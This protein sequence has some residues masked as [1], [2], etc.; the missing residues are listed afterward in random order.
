[1][2]TA[3]T[4]VQALAADGGNPAPHLALL[5]KARGQVLAGHPQHGEAT[6]DKA[7]NALAQVS[8][9]AGGGQGPVL[10]VLDW[11]NE[12]TTK[13]YTHPRK[14]KIR[15]YSSTVMEP[16][17]SYDGQLLLFNN[18]NTEADTDLHLARKTGDLEF[19]YIRVLDE[20]RSDVMEAAPSLDNSGALY[21][22][23]LREYFQ[24]RE[25]I[26]RGQLEG[27]RVVGTEVIRGQ[28]TPARNGLLNM[29]VSVS[30]QGD[31]LYISAARFVAGS[32]APKESNLQLARKVNGQFEIDRKSARLFARVNTD[33]L[34][35][36]PS[37]SGDGL[38]LY[39]TRAS[40]LIAKG[41]QGGK[42]RIMVA[43]RKNRNDPFE[44]PSVIKAITGFVEAPTITGDKRYLYYHAKDP[45]G[46]L[47]LYRVTRQ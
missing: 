28:I 30:P 23:S 42:L 9:T 44:E 22:T 3:I 29:D 4:Q 32:N 16:F 43:T 41:S 33:A 47:S 12:K 26:L 19:Q 5:E 6:L 8:Q 35:Y 7:L 46:V 40:Q 31:E 13:L 34:E 2:Q 18:S 10:P 17:I 15:G 14:I 21:F 20:T 39:F 25:T 45:K 36:A 24:T 27:D 37:I 38:E 11:S 1:M